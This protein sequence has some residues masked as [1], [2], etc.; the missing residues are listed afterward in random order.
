VIQASH[1]PERSDLPMRAVVVTELNG[2]GSVQIDDVQTPSL[3][4]Q[5]SPG[6][7]VVIGVE[8]AAVSF[9]DVLQSRGRYQMQP[10]LPFVPG[11][12]VAG[13]V[14]DASPDTGFHAG[15]RVYA[16]SMIGGMAEQAVAPGFLTFPLPDTLSMAEGAATILNY[17][18]CYF[19]LK[20]RAHLQ[21]GERVLVHGA[22]GG[23]GTAAIQV[24]RAL[25]AH[26]TAV[27]SSDT[28]AAVARQAGADAVIRSDDAWKDEVV[29]AGGADV[30]IDPV[31]GHMF[32]DSLRAL[33]EGGRLVVIG[34]AAGAIPEVRVNRLLLNNTSVVGAGWGAFVFTKPEVN[35]TIGAAIEQMVMAGHVRPVVGA[36]FPLEAAADAFAVIEERRASGK[37]ILDVCRSRAGTAR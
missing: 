10:A 1:L 22:A 33:N 26:V 18:T 24:A 32:L 27:V 30:I 29:A 4:H 11:A 35:R 28:K 14:I 9:P 17:H 19:A 15:D 34:F 6:S 16:F 20:L 31:G 23:V 2:P 37:V 3:D 36:R 25:G 12:E 13:T 5:L 21:V 8:A 7:G